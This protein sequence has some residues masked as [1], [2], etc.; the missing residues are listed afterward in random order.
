MIPCNI[1]VLSAVNADAGHSEMQVEVSLIAV[2]PKKAM[3]SQGSTS[4][5]RGIR[6]GGWTA[7]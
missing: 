6:K 4:S 1:R 5:C 2:L 7:T 3:L